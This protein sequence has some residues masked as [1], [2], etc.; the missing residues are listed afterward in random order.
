MMTIDR[1]GTMSQGAKW[2]RG[3]DLMT[4]EQQLEF[5]GLMEARF[6][7]DSMR[8]TELDAIHLAEYQSLADRLEVEFRLDN[9]IRGYG[10]AD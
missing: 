2:V 6:H 5:G 10:H 3:Y 9:Q 1:G 7:S 8:F 4:L